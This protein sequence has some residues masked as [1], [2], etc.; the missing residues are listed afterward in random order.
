VQQ[1]QVRES[2]FAKETRG[3]P[4]RAAAEPIDAPKVN[5]G[6]PSGSSQKDSE[7]RDADLK[8]SEREA[9]E[10]AVPIADMAPS[11]GEDTGEG[12]RGGGAPVQ[13]GEEGGP[14]PQAQREGGGRVGAGAGQ[15]VVGS[16]HGRRDYLEHHSEGE[17][18][19]GTHPHGDEGHSRRQNESEVYGTI[20]FLAATRTPRAGST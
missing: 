8:K 15:Q 13:G 17:V 19:H 9:A 14:H 11:A 6:A 18:G 5:I 1:A 10:L 12:R 7:A 3:E 20:T 16:D 4:V 2:S